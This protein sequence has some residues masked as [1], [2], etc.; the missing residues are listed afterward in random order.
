[1]RK[2]ILRTL[3]TLPEAQ[4]YQ[5]LD[6][7]EFLQ[8]RYGQAADPVRTG[9]QAFAERL[10]DRMRARSIAARTMSGTMKVVSTAGRMIDGL[11]GAV[12]AATR[13]LLEESDGGAAR[14]AG[15][16]PPALEP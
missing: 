1:M 4:L 15:A 16:S 10:E 8:L 2:R 12:A 13:P 14:R 11:S 7:V 5:V 9:F 3:E 6:Y